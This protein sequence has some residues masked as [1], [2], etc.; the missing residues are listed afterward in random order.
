[1]TLSMKAIFINFMRKY[2]ARHAAV[3]SSS[4]QGTLGRN[5]PPGSSAKWCAEQKGHGLQL[6]DGGWGIEQSSL[7]K[8]NP[9]RNSLP[10]MP[11]TW[12]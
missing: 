3:G 7:A 6:Q 11:T 8:G 9:L 1:M 5:V 12:P 4:K 2:T 10:A